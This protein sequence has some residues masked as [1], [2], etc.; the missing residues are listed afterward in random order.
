M[1]QRRTFEPYADA[2]GNTLDSLRPQSLVK[3]WVDPN[4]PCS[5]L[6]LCKGN[7]RLDSPGSSLFEGSAMNTFV[8]VYCVFA[9][10]DILKSGTGLASLLHEYVHEH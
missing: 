4:I 5:H 9:R 1:G 7:N 8:E 3:F 6:L 10:H 2:V